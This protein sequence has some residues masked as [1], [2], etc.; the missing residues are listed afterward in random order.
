MPRRRTVLIIGSALA[1]SLGAGA[2]WFLT[3]PL[4]PL[5][6]PGE[7]PA[8]QQE[9]YVS[10]THLVFIDTAPE[11]V[12]TW[13]NDPSLNLEDLVEFEDGT[14]AVVGTQPL[15]GS[16]Q[17]GER[18]GFRRRVEFEDGHYLAEEMLVDSPE[19][20]QY[21]IWGFTR[22]TQ[23][24]AVDHGVAEFRYLPEGDGT[25]LSW[26]YSLMPTTGLLR[27]AVESFV[28]QTMD[29]MMEATLEAIREGAESS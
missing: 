11:T 25:R 12:Y 13:A 14:P 22:P 24:V 20:F 7:R 9:G 29:P 27:S 17:I 26:T 19:R 4:S 6:Y 21:M 2:W 10:T 28:E 18:A 3:P 16:E 15:M 1:L 23:R 8:L 5:S